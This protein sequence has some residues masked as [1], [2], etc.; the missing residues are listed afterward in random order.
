MK[1]G[2]LVFSLGRLLLFELLQ[3]FRQWTWERIWGRRGLRARRY[4]HVQGAFELELPPLSTVAIDI[5]GT[6]KMEENT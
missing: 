4:G 2:D 6:T 5:R 3:I 1:F